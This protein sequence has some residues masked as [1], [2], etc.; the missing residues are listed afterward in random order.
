ME[1]MARWSAVSPYPELGENER[2]GVRLVAAAMH[3]GNPL[4]WL[5]LRA[6]LPVEYPAQERLEQQ[7]RLI[8]EREGRVRLTLLGALHDDDSARDLEV[9]DRLVR[10]AHAAY[11]PD[12]L[13]ILRSEV[14]DAAGVDVAELERVERY[15]RA[16]GIDL[17]VGVDHTRNG[18]QRVAISEIVRRSAT[19]EEA[20]Y[21]C[22]Q[23]RFFAPHPAHEREPDP[24]RLHL[25]LR[26]IRVE[27]F[28]ALADLSLRLPSQLTVLVGP[29]GVGKSTVL[30]AVA[31][32]GRAARLGL[33]EVLRGQDP[34]AGVVTAGADR[35]PA[36]HFE[37]DLDLGGTEHA[38]GEFGF[39]L[40]RAGRTVVVDREWLR[41]RYGTD[42]RVWIDARRGVARMADVHGRLSDEPLYKP[43]GE[44][45]LVTAS[46]RQEVAAGVGA[47]LGSFVLL[48]RDPA[49]VAF[50]ER[51]GARPMEELLA[52]LASTDSDVSAL[53]EAL[54]SFLPDVVALQRHVV[55]GEAPQLRVVERNI[56]RP[57]AVHELSAGA[58]Q[59]LLIACLYVVRPTP[60]IVLLEEPD[61]GLHVGKLHALR[62]LLREVATRS[63]IVA[64]SHSPTFV[65]LLDSQRE[66]IALDREA[67]SVR[68]RPLAE[69]L[70]SKRWLDAFGE[71]RDA[72]VR[73]G[74]ERAR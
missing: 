58:R 57:L 67:G 34:L 28:R 39:A 21:V 35:G 25:T 7:L 69:A 32:V 63:V 38:R 15:A 74:L 41:T 24:D 55:T 72:F 62:D 11:S 18:E 2:E 52:Q 45:A 29:N 60:R 42:E 51:R 27:R 6:G 4:T 23:N 20:I 43:A 47:G 64:T 10:W 70:S 73:S 31:F 5:Q 13:R 33:E 40:E 8:E 9:L 50:P 30:D 37:F 71:P 59:L 19:L 1:A 56:A 65:G 14:A 46:P 3:E 54:R 44:L 61:A 12:G 16:L 48:D 22:Y 53:E 17:S 26:A 68:A 49:I 36:F 66:V